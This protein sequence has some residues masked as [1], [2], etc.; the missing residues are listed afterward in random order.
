VVAVPAVPEDFKDVFARHPAGVAVVLWGDG[1]QVRGMTL[2]SLASVSADPPRFVF[3]VA[4]RSTR[5]PT[6]LAAPAFS[7]NVLGYDDVHL[8]RSLAVQGH[9][10]VPGDRVDAVV[11]GTPVLRGARAWLAAR[12]VTRFD[13]GPSV[14]LLAEAFHAQ[15]AD[16]AEPLV[17]LDREY[18]GV[19]SA[20][21][22][23]HPGT[24]EQE[25]RSGRGAASLSWRAGSRT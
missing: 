1:G 15:T 24:P 23:A 25:R 6:L 10:R 18:R 22:P 5:L 19:R 20:E 2:S 4:A 12:V 13:A 9:D 21:L 11:P 14:L 3:S 17:Y 8:A 16:D 7:M